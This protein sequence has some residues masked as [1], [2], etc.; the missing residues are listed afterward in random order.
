MLIKQ[1]DDKSS[2]IALL[3]SFLARADVPA[4]TK[5]KI[6]V[7]LRNMRSGL[8]GENDAAYEIN[9]S[10]GKSENWMLIHDLRVEHK[11]RVAQIDH[12]LINRLMEVY[13]CE[14]KRFCEGI[15][16][17]EQGECATFFKGRA[18]GIASPFEQNKKHVLVLDTIFEN[19][20]VPVPRRLGM[21][22]NPTLI[23]LILV[24]KNA[25]ISRPKREFEELSQIMKVDQA[26][27]WVERNATKSISVSSLV[28]K[29]VSAKT[30][31]DFARGL[32]SLHAP[33]EVDW[34][35][36]FGVPTTEIP[37]LTS[38]KVES[39]PM[40]VP[41]AIISDNI[42]EAEASSKYTCAKC[43][44]PLSLAIARFCWKNKRRFKGATYCMDC[45][46]TAN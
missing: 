4:D 13:I 37:M 5:Q 24:S 33:I 38:F 29:L 25:R 41:A 19:E 26:M 45:Q 44:A 22:I 40:A 17:N 3:S 18:Q 10:F 12:I 20:I 8:K 32:A 43:T 46:N 31:E 34:R 14:S 21:K 39:S 42:T 28:S 35:A 27:S 11:G 16:V 6:E 23:S 15:A 7:E 1:A 36:R 2:S 30:L 9:F